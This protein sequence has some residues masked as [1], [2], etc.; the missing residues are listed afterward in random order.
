[1]SGLSLSCRLFCDLNKV[2][3]TTMDYPP[4]LSKPDLTKQ[5]M[6]LALAR[7]IFEMHYKNEPI[8]TKGQ[9]K[10][11]DN[12]NTGDLEKAARVLRLAG[13]IRYLDDVGRR[14]VFVSEPNNFDAIAS[15]SGANEIDT[16][17]IKDAVMRLACGNHRSSLEIEQIADRLTREL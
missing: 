10:T 5:G 1:M 7:C 2:I 3:N 13:F 11:S 12:L 14:S 9:I 15:S 17:M 6:L 4:W 8:F 16:I